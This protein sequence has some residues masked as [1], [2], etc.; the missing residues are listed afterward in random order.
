MKHKTTTSRGYYLTICLLIVVILTACT[1]DIVYVNRTNTIYRNR[2]INK[3]IY[4]NI[5]H[6][7]L[8][9]TTCPEPNE[10]NS[11]IYD[12]QYVLG[13]IRQLKHYET[14]Q[15][16]YWNNSECYDE[17]NRTKKEI[18]LAEKELCVWNSSWC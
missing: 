8:Q 3:T 4:K 16:K 10:I 2:T 11:P 14:Q 7:V 18:A 1:Q 12:R 15:V 5:T 17:L 13:L 6:L 9:N